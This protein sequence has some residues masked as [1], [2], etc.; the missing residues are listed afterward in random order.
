MIGKG[1]WGLLTPLVLGLSPADD[2]IAACLFLG[3]NAEN[4]FLF[5]IDSA[6]KGSTVPPF[7][8]PVPVP[9][10]VSAA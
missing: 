2:V 9:P 5:V 8:A 3:G 1:V 10:S 4:S 6:P 7:T